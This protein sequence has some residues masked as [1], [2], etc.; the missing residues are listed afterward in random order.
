MMKQTLIL[1]MSSMLLSPLVCVKSHACTNFL[2]SKGASTDGSVMVTYAADSH[3]LYGELYYSP[4]ATH[5]PGEMRQ[6]Y[7]WDS[8]KHIGEI[9]QVE[10]TYLRVGNMNEHQLAIGE[11]TFGGRSELVNPK[12]LIDYGSLIYIALE[13]A[14]TAREA[15]KVMTEL[16]DQYGYYSSGESFSIADPHEVWLMEMIGKGPGEKGAL[17][18]ARRVPNGYF[19]AH[20]NQARIRRF[21]L[22]D[23]KNC[24]YAKDV[25]SFARKKGYFSGKDEDFSFADAYAPLGFGALRFCE[26]RVWKAFRRVAPSLKLSEAYVDGSKGEVPRLPLWIKPDKKLGVR[27]VMELMRDHFEGTSLDLSQ[28]VG[29]GPYKLPY[30]WRPLV[31]EHEGKKYFNERATSTQQTAFSFV[32]QSRSWLPHAIGGVLWFGMDDTFSTVY[33]PLYCAITRPPENFAVGVGSL[34]DFTWESGFWVFNF[35]ANYAYSRYSDMIVDI[36]LI[37]RDLE[38]RFVASQPNVDRAALALYKRS[39]TLAVD[40]LTEY[41]LDQVKM[42]LARWR[43]LGEHLMVKYLDGNVKDE[44]GKVTHPPY[45]KSWYKRIIEESGTKYEMKKLKGDEATST[46]DTPPGRCH[47]IP[48]RMDLIPLCLPDMPQ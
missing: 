46:P 28:G 6:V 1:F 4:A 22:N 14:R 16:V 9:P 10:Q 39:P 30:R 3:E 33:I 18:V 41:S 38:G 34:N 20:A 26:A 47:A 48:G 36:Q 44:H 42:T 21:P 5:V 17:W 37:Q 45:D 27:D 12:G 31:W 2:V 8:G 15:I 23:K 13:R 40:Y 24:L 19:S 29:A 11:T 32:S 35:V 25:I 43:K 7:D